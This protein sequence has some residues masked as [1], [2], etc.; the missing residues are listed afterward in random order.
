M[1]GRI[2]PLY[3]K[4]NFLLSKIYW[5][6]FLNYEF[7]HHNTINLGMAEIHT[8]NSQFLTP[9]NVQPTSNKTIV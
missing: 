2:G 5:D 7:T 1:F 9:P 8:S 3:E 6:F 4:H